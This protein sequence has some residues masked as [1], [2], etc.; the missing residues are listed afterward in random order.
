MT[1]NPGTSGAALAPW[2]RD[3]FERQLRAM[4]SAYHI[5]HPFNLRMQAGACS[6]EQIRGWIANRFYYQFIIPKKDAA[7]LSN[8]DDRA[9]RR[10]W[11][12]RILDHDGYDDYEGDAQGGMEAWTQ[13]GEATG[14]PR[15]ELWSLQHVVPAVRFACD[16]YVDF[17]RRSPWQEAVCSSLTEMFAPQIHKDRLAGWPR[18]YPWVGAQ[19]LEYFR[20]RIPLAQR[21]VEHGLAVTLDYFTTRQQQE[22]AL[23]ILK[24][25]LDILWAMLDAID[26]AYPV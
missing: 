19:G 23:G 2:P 18:H 25:K 20:S 4:G 16:A 17:A 14:I 21:D 12:A 22:R 6:P 3:E 24:F 15:A 8:C 10:L 5:H 9:T 26:K 13:L 7:I 1:S 11:I